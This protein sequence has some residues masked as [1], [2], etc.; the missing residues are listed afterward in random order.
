[1]RDMSRS[2]FWWRYEQGVVPAVPSSRTDGVR[3]VPWRGAHDRIARAAPRRTGRLQRVPHGPRS[4]GRTRSH[5][6]RPST[7]GDCVRRTRSADAAGRPPRRAAILRERHV[8]QRVLPR[9]DDDERRRRADGAAVD[10]T[11]AARNVRAVSRIAATEPCAKRL[12]DVSSGHC[13]AHRR[14]C[15]DRYDRRLQR[16]PRRF[17][18]ARA[19]ARS[20]REHVHDLDRRRCAPSASERSIGPARSRALRCVSC[21]S[22]DDHGAGPHRQR[23]AGGGRRDSRMGSRGRDMQLGLVSR[24][25]APGVDAHGR[26]RVRYLP[27]HPAEYTEPHARHVADE[28]RGMSSAHCHGERSDHRRWRAKRAHERSDR[29]SMI[30]FLSSRS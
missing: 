25:V 29:C 20:R 12:R 21:G 22:C 18:V 27:R 2:G 13:S 23:S 9:R 26:G 17:L 4:V 1:M 15:P 28:L 14:R 8:P 11:C 16:L 6:R 30:R 10:R 7:C 24:N 19:A 3:D 5:P